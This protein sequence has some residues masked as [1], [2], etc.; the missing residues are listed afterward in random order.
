MGR[1]NHRHA[2]RRPQAKR[3]EDGLPTTRAL[4]KAP[5]VE[6]MVTPHGRCHYRHRK[7]KFRAHEIERALKQ[8]IASYRAKGQIAGLPTRGYEC[9]AA[10]GGCGAWHLTSQTETHIRGRA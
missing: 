8:A 5:S 10:E 6:G 3:R 7:H 9:K 1:K 2:G 4:P